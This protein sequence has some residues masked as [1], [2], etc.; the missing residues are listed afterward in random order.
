MYITYS[1]DLDL[2]HEQCILFPGSNRLMLN[3][4]QT[5]TDSLGIFRILYLTD[6]SST[7][8]DSCIE[9]DYL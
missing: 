9:Y 7:R 6:Q 5:A 3:D 1:A 8:P 4:Q 2:D